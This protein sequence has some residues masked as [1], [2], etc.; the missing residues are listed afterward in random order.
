MG[1]IIQSRVS[2]DKII[3]QVAL[4]ESESLALKGRVRNVHMF[5]L[6]LFTVES[7]M[8]EKGKDGVTKYFVIPSVFKSKRKSQLSDL[9]MFET[10]QKYFFI[11]VCDKEQLSYL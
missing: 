4:D 8:V 6:D 10:D 7:K 2:G 9:Q 5:S 1:E 3:Y 11:Y